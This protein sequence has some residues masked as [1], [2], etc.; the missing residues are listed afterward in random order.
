QTGGAEAAARQL[1]WELWMN[2]PGVSQSHS[3]YTGFQSGNWQPAFMA[4]TGML[5]PVVGQGYILVNIATTSVR[6][7][8]N[9]VIEPLNQDDIDRAYQ[10]FL[11]AENAFIRDQ[12]G[13]RFN[14]LSNVPILLVPN[15][16]QEEEDSTAFPGWEFAEMSRDE[17]IR[18]LD[19]QTG[20]HSGIFFGPVPLDT[21]IAVARQDSLLGGGPAWERLRAQADDWLNHP[22]ENFQA[23]R[24]SLYPF[25]GERVNAWIRDG[26]G[27]NADHMDE[28]LAMYTGAEALE[29]LTSFFRPIVEDWAYGRGT[30]HEIVGG[31]NQLLVPWT[32]EGQNR[33]FG[34]I[35]RRMAGD[36]IRSYRI[37]RMNPMETQEGKLADASLEAHLT[38]MTYMAVD[39]R[40]RAAAT[41]LAAAVDDARKGVEVPEVLGHAVHRMRL[42]R[43]QIED[44]KP[45]VHVRPRIL[46]GEEATTERPSDD[47]DFLVSVVAD[48]AKYPRPYRYDTEWILVESGP[49]GAEDEPADLS[50]IVRVYDAE[51][52][53]VG[54]SVFVELGKFLLEEPRELVPLEPIVEVRVG[55]PDEGLVPP[56]EP[57]EPE[58]GEPVGAAL[59]DYL[60]Y[61]ELAVYF[62][63]ARDTTTVWDWRIV[64]LAPQPDTVTASS[65]VFVPGGGELD[66]TDRAP[67]GAPAAFVA[68]LGYIWGEDRAGPG[69]YLLQTCHPQDVSGTFGSTMSYGGCRTP[70][71]DPDTG[72]E[73]LYPWQ[74]EGSFEVGAVSLV[75]KDLIAEQG[76]VTFSEEGGP[77]FTL[78]NVQSG[79]GGGADIVYTWDECLNPDLPDE[80]RVPPCPRHGEGWTTTRHVE[81]TRLDLP[82]P[83]EL[84]LQAP[85]MGELQGRLSPQGELTQAPVVF[86][87]DL[88]P[89]TEATRDLVQR[90]AVYQTAEVHPPSA[91]EEEPDLLNP[92]FISPDNRVNP[93]HIHNDYRREP[94]DPERPMGDWVRDGG[95][96]WFLPIQVRL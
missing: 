50:A 69:T 27:A 31:D 35:A 70:W 92:P 81:R 79:A 67:A 34:G 37:V 23:K 1:A 87:E 19:E 44:A 18:I 65:G 66:Y 60:I 17:M 24:A 15:P 76:A 91:D 73:E 94:G 41:R 56:L 53:Q 22:R 11:G 42:D 47:V 55:D 6:I 30:F 2:V 52:N 25:Y 80:Q 72:E 84:D 82:L 74:D 78:E 96:H 40:L 14:V 33:F 68:D 61:D 21:A 57:G 13:M 32:T 63:P 45:H 8:G 12:R 16:D 20:E 83:T 38:R 75:L 51:N 77:W 29:L 36:F 3:V 88:M 4:G 89:G 90:V 62:Q 64:R 59:A 7:V 93:Y 46:A 26:S 54:D 49:E 5:M 43:N 9:M 10:G 95:T 86:L 85:I 39:K 48:S 58:A 28:L 71:T